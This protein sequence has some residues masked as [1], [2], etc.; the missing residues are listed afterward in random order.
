MTGRRPA[1][2]ILA[3]LLLP[4]G[5]G[6]QAPTA[7]GPAFQGVELEVA[8]VGDPAI[9][10]AVRVQSGE[11]TAETGARLTIRSAPVAPGEA[12]GVEILVFPGDR[13]GDL[14]DA[15]ALAFLPETAVRGA[16][17]LPLGEPDD[18]DQDGD[19]PDAPPRRDPLDFADI[20]QPYREQV[21]KYGD[22]RIGL[23]L[24]GS[25]LVLA[26]RRDAFTSEA[27][28]A[29]AEAAKVALKPPET[30]EELD[31]LARF[32]GG[33]DWDGDGQPDHGIAL[34]LGPDPDGVGDATLLARAAALGQPP[35]QYALL[36]DA[37]AMEPRVASP[38][39]VEALAAL[40]ALADAGPPEMA[41]FDADAARAAFRDGRV[42]LLIDRAERAGRWTD[43]KAPRSVGVAPLPGSPRVYDPLGQQWI[44]PTRP[45]RI[46]Y[47]PIGGGWLIGLGA[48]AE[49]RAREAALALA[50]VLASPE[51]AQAIVSD[52]AF[53]MTPV[54]TS[55]LTLGL[56][57][58]RAAL[59]VD[60][61][62]W[63]QAVQETFGAPR[64][65]IDLRIPEAD[66][67]LADLDAARADAARGVKE[68]QA[69]LDEVAS[70][71]RARTERL[72]RDRQL[73]H[74]RRSLNRLPTTTEPPP[75]SAGRGSAPS[76]P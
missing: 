35:D 60:P 62:G 42:A 8:A 34:A 70:A 39:F 55:H 17:R 22:D 36:F 41:T 45:N 20:A 7:T 61:R 71:W 2:I 16:P 63:G 51:T 11:W 3:L 21:S 67:Y 58:P 44:T 57:E 4:A 66:G 14:V 23:P 52:P 75:R 38:P 25:A 12:A 37:D 19:D 65:V 6:P 72:G 24:G 46:G 30:W 26:Y 59:G 1:V 48:R 53:P 69:A 31:A 27:N 10:E 5:C 54:R 68:P 56:P 40:V 76:P 47:L 33:R 43:P 49:G 9:L 13:L 28:R 32:F 18:P 15:G 64:V 50:R 74:Y 29:A 73:W